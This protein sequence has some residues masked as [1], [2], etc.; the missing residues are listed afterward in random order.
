MGITSRHASDVLIR[1]DDRDERAARNDAMVQSAGRTM[2]N[3]FNPE[4][5]QT[6]EGNAA[7]ARKRKY[8]EAGITPEM[9]KKLHA[10]MSSGGGGDKYGKGFQQYRTTAALDAMAAG[11]GFDPRK[12][13]LPANYEL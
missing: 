7:I 8:K 13:S 4:H 3:V 1:P 6:S 11:H 5:F 9:E 10:A 2:G 12:W